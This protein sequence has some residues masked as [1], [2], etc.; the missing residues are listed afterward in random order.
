MSRVLGNLIDGPV[1]SRQISEAHV[2]KRVPRKPRQAGALG[3]PV[4]DL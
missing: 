3:N 2:T 1:G 4:Y